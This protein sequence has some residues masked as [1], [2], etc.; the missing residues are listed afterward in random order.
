MLVIM[1]L[2]EKEPDLSA[3]FTLIIIASLCRFVKGRSLPIL[4]VFK[5][6]K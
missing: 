6:V 2:S 3:L 5:G 4:I 1:F